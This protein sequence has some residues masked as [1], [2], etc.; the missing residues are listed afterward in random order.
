MSDNKNTITP[1]MVVMGQIGRAHGLKGEV[2]AMSFTADPM[3][4]ID[5]GDLSD[6]K[7]RVFKIVNARVQGNGL[8]LRLNG[9]TTREAAEALNGVE[10]LVPRDV[11][12]ATED[13]DD[14]YHADLIGLDA[15]GT[16]GATLGKIL[17]VHNF[18]AGDMLEVRLVSGK[19]VFVPFTKAAV[20]EVSVKS[21][22]VTLDAEAAGLLTLDETPE[23]GEDQGK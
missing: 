16:D 5:Y 2:H 19:Q 18:G 12:P 3:A 6:A 1:S 14:F 17:A 22:S 7:G 4:L 13:D 10:L 20:P 15:I 8:V 23:A 11:L 9:V 21:G